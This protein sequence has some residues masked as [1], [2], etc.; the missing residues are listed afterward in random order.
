MKTIPITKARENLYNVVQETIDN[1]IP[2]QITSKGG[3]VILLSKEDW[4]AIQ[5]TIYLSS[6][7]GFRESL[8][9][10]DNGEWIPENEVDW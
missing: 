8:V 9:D 7:K 10:A 1:S 4:N 5:E 2:V 6:V 3:E